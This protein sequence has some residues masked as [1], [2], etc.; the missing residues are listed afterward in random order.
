MHS[1]SMLVRLA[2]QPGSRR[3][4][5]E[6][7]HPGCS[8]MPRSTLPI[9]FSASSLELNS[10]AR[11]CS[12]ASHAIPWTLAHNQ[13]CKREYTGAYCPTSATHSALAWR[14]GSCSSRV[15]RRPHE[16][17][18][19]NDFDRRRPMPGGLLGQ[20]LCKVPQQASLTIPQAPLSRETIWWST[21]SS[22]NLL[23]IL[24]DSAR[25]YLFPNRQ[26][27]DYI[28]SADII[29]EVQTPRRSQG[30]IRGGKLY[31]AMWPT[32]SLAAIRDLL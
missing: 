13:H 8:V 1:A 28:H 10:S 31:Q 6:G 30:Q 22:S 20:S 11:C 15:T 2:I 29:A 3:G 5:V 18:F 19:P 32:Q 25:R 12:E 4:K 17:H 16:L 14:T 9:P 23:G 21:A 24:G 26:H 7:C 27:P